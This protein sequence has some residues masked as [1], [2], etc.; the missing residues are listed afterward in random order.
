MQRKRKRKIPTSKRLVVKIKTVNNEHI[1]GCIHCKGHQKNNTHSK[2]KLDKVISLKGRGNRNLPYKIS[3]AS[4]KH[5][6][7]GLIDRTI[8]I[9]SNHRSIEGTIVD[10]KIIRCKGTET[11][12]GNL[13]DNG[14]K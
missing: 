7:N 8:K 5:T 11:P 6:A 12:G 2:V 1:T 9:K 10:A 3:S 13:P 14:E 4:P